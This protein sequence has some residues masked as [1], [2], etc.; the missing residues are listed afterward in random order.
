MSLTITNTIVSRV[1]LVFVVLVSV[2]CFVA[3]GARAQDDEGGSSTKRAKTYEIRDD[4][5]IFLQSEMDIIDLIKAVSEITDETYLIHQDVKSKQVT[6]ITPEGGMKKEDVLK[7][8]E[9]ILNMNGLT[10]IESNSIN[11]VLPVDESATQAPLS[12]TPSE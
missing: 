6:I 3:G 11:K 12:E 7:L 8:F 2:S 5:I 4:S 1:I 10:V 9:V